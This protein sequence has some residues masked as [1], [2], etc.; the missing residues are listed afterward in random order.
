MSE[1]TVVSEI[2]EE[3]N[4]QTENSPIRKGNIISQFPFL[5]PKGKLKNFD[6]DDDLD[7]ERPSHEVIRIEH[8]IK[9]NIALVG[10]QVWRGALLLGDLLIYLGVNGK[11]DGKTVLELGAGTGLT[12]FVAAIYA[13]KV[14]CT[15][16]NGGGI[17]EL[18]KINALANSKLMKAQFEVL[19]LDFKNIG[20]GHSLLKGIQLTDIIIA[21]DVIYDDDVTAAFVSTIQKILNTNPPKTMYI[22]LEK[23][24]VFTIEHMD[25][26]AP[27][28]ETFLSLLDK[29]KSEW[30]VEQL[31]LNFPKYFTYDRV[32][33][34]VLWKITSK[35]H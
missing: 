32:K 17:L 11:L 16:I 33:E 5:L 14:I 18:I 29:V 7:I 31:P 6:E 20:W 15:D 9:T 35:R 8:S 10:L 23:R 12:S 30:I 24:Y 34:L 26:V 1:L 28:Y 4:Y 21:A 22:V 25:S 19:P 27:C 2:Y 3:Y 13:K